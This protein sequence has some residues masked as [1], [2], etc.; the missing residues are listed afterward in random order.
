MNPTKAALL[1]AAAGFAVGVGGILLSPWGP[2]GG[3]GAGKTE[4]EETAPKGA[5]A[6]M[7]AVVRM[8]AAK[9]GEIEI[10]IPALGVVAL[11]SQSAVR[12]VSRGGG[13][14]TAGDRRE[15]EEGRAGAVLVRPH[16]R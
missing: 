16:P 15:G 2:G 5:P 1:G 7:A 11:R 8:E 13:V 12:G 14:I 4:D 3:G 6:E 9:A 10:R